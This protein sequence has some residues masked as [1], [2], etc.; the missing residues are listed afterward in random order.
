ME[1]ALFGYGRRVIYGMNRV[2]QVMVDVVLDRG[3]KVLAGTRGMTDH[4]KEIVPVLAA[5]K[6]L[7]AAAA[8]A[9]RRRHSCGARVCAPAACRRMRRRPWSAPL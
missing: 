7:K 4:G 5:E 8:R 6:S 1:E 2:A 3:K 9:K